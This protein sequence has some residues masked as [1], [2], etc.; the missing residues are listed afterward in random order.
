MKKNLITFLLMF[1]L[2]SCGKDGN[3]GLAYLQFTWDWYVDSYSDSNSNTPSTINKNTSYKV[4]PGTYTY[5]YNCSDGEGG[6]W[7]YEGTYTISINKGEE[8]ALFSDGEDGRDKH[9]TFSLSGNGG[10]FGT[11][12]NKINRHKDL[13][14]S[15]IDYSSFNKQ[16][17]GEMETEII[18]SNNLVIE[19]TKQK[20]ILEKLN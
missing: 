11:K 9:Y 4:N 2:M 12:S 8:A 7:G 19:I 13:I 5:D 20:F 16:Y 3:D 14:P 17:V 6:Y 15:N 10:T 1:L 18:Y